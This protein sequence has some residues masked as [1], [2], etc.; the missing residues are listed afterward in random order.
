REA[1]GARV[2]DHVLLRGVDQ[3]AAAL[4]HLAGKEARQRILPPADARV[5]FIDGSV[6]AVDAQLVGAHQAGQSG[7]DDADIE[8]PRVGGAGAGT[9]PRRASARRAHTGERAGS[10]DRA[11]RAEKFAA[12]LFGSVAPRNSFGSGDF[13]GVAVVAETHGAAKTI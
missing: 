2:V 6:H 12:A 13:V 7:A 10:R 3:L 1:E 11:D 4:D 8:R 5:A 9:A